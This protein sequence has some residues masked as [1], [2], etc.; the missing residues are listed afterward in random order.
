MLN[1]SVFANVFLNIMGNTKKQFI[2]K[3]YIYSYVFKLLSPSKYSLFDS[4]D[5]SRHF[6]TTQNSFW[7]RRCWCLLVLLSF[8]VSP[9]PHGQNIS[10]WG[11]FSSRETKKH[12]VQGKIGWKGGWDMGVM[13]FL[14]KNCWTLSCGCTLMNQMKLSKHIESP[15]RTQWSQMQPLTNNASWYTERDGFLQH[16]PSGGK[17]VL[18]GTRPPD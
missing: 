7:T 14:V 6:F 4:I 1:T 18:Q 13:P 15:Q 10:L 17:P 8:F 9:L 2:K 3:L 16:P 5:L 11:L 12:I